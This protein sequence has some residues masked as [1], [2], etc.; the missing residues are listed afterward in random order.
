MVR[1]DMSFFAG[2]C[3]GGFPM[4]Q[5]EPEN[6]WITVREIHAKA[7]AY[8]RLHGNFFPNVPTGSYC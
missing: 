7:K 5:D 1:Q 8:W 3:A 6:Q 2:P 4:E